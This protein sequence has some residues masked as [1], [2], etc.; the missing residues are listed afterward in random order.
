M[1]GRHSLK[2]ILE[3]L[4]SDP[5]GIKV[6]RVIKD[7]LKPGIA[8]QIRRE[9]IPIK[10]EDLPGRNEFDALIKQAGEVG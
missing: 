1:T 7:S 10:I 3:I 6:D 4:R 8:E 2:E 5:V 9:A